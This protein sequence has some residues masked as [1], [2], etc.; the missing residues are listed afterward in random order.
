MKWLIGLIIVMIAIISGL[1][2]AGIVGLSIA[3]DEWRKQDGE[4]D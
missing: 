1:I 4:D 3:L 2:F